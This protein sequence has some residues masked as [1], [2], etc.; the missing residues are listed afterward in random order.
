MRKKRSC[1]EGQVHGM[2]HLEIDDVLTIR[3]PV[4]PALAGGKDIEG[5]WHM[6]VQLPYALVVRGTY[7]RIPVRA[8]CRSE[9]NLGTDVV[10]V[11]RLTGAVVPETDGKVGASC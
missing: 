10:L 1:G 8:P 7:H 11:R 9:G 5:W 2:P 3:L 6:D 4:A